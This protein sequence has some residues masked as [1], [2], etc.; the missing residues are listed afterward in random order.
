MVPREAGTGVGCVVLGRVELS[1]SGI[2][3]GTGAAG[4]GLE[5]KARRKY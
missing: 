5:N 2:E 4:R 3:D 1:W